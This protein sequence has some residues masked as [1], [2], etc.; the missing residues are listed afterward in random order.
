MGSRACIGLLMMLA[1]GVGCSGPHDAAGS[2]VHGVGAAA[3]SVAGTGGTDV[4]AGARLFDGNCAACHQ[5]DARGIPGVYPSLVGSPVLLGDPGALAR[6]VIE[7]R[8][9]PSMPAGRYATA[10]AKFGWMKERDAATLLTYLR[11]HFGN[12]APA[13]D[14]ATV[15]QALAPAD[16]P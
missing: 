8:R 11:S 6:W 10:M 9:P 3:Q 13:V 4:E 12:N 15:A 14:E 16:K 7:G 2:G 1:G 5:R